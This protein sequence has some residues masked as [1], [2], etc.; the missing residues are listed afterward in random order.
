MHRYD[1]EMK[2][3]GM[4]MRPQKGEGGRKLYTMKVES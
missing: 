1:G 4:R 3:M 2:E